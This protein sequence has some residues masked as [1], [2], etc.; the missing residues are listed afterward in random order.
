MGDTRLVSPGG[1]SPRPGKFS[2]E[3][4]RAGARLA[5]GLGAHRRFVGLTDVDQGPIGTCLTETPCSFYIELKPA[6]HFMKAVFT[7]LSTLCSLPASR[8]RDCHGVDES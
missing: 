4:T 1:S 2:A 6:K 5:Q 3:R 8:V 7:I